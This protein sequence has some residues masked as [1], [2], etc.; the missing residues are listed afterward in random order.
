[1]QKKLLM[2][3]LIATVLAKAVFAENTNTSPTAIP[4]A[5]TSSIP[6]IAGEKIVYMLTIAIPSLS[7]TAPQPTTISF[8]LTQKAFTDQ[9]GAIILKTAD[10][11]PDLGKE[12][13]HWVATS[14]GGLPAQA[15]TTAEADTIYDHELTQNQ[16]QPAQR[17]LIKTLKSLSISW[18]RY[19]NSSD[20][21]PFY[22]TPTKPT[23]KKDVKSPWCFKNF[24]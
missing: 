20:V 10:I 23:P 13:Y 18:V 17:A 6:T 22:G 9:H 15:L 21:M 2:S 3:F 11:L 4:A 1:M 16:W 24:C 8:D 5:P 14:L 7:S 19:Q 12:Q